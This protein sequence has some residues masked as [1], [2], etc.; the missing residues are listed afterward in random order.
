[1]KTDQDTH[2]NIYIYNFKRLEAFS[3]AGLWALE[4]EQ[5]KMDAKLELQEHLENKSPDEL[6][7]PSNI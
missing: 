7:L 2:V 5:L 6:K 4:N 1:M 3:I